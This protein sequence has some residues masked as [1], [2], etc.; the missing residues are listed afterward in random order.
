MQLKVHPN[1]H[2]FQHEDG[3]PFFYLADTAWMLHNKLTLDE[4][5]RLFADRAAKGFTAVQ[6]LVFRDLFEPNTPNVA[7]V[8]PFATDED[9]RAVRLNPKWIEHVIAVTRLADEHGLIMGLLPTWGDKWNE[10]SNSA[11]PVIMDRDSARRYCQTLSNALA[12]CPNVIWILGG[13]SPVRT[14]AE[15]DIV[16]A[17]GEGIRAGGSAER[18]MTFH[19]EGSET[20]AIF[21]SEPWLDFNAMQTGHARPGQPNYTYIERLY[22]QRPHKPCIDLEPNYELSP[23]FWFGKAGVQPALT[24]VF[25]AHEVRKA[26]YRSVLAGAAGFTYGCEPIRP[27]V[28]PGDRI[29]IWE[30]EPLPTWDEALSAP[31]SSQL[32]LLKQSLLER[33]YFCRV[34]AQELLRP[35]RR[36]GAWVDRLAIGLPSADQQNTDPAAHIR[37]ARCTQG[38]YIMAY[39]PVRQA[40]LLD[41]TGLDAKRLRLS[42]FD[43]EACE[44]T[45]DYEIDNPGT[46]RYIPQRDLD[47]FIIVDAI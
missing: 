9:M 26:Y 24:T 4:A 25:T 13:D 7:G 5:G 37:V 23:M 35:I 2:Y 32:E 8:K 30:S 15:A 6:A 33:P 27:M 3:T 11:G 34:P 43:P 28:R 18:L 39:L 12:D 31:G 29:H 45:A 10:H 42:V 14:Q 47:T 41:T 17:M 19:P 22:H 21:H 16:R 20:S 1:G 38:R 46:L 40:L 44:Q 36:A